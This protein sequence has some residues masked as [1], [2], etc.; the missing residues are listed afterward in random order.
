MA[1]FNS[2]C[3]SASPC[4]TP[5]LELE[6]CLR[7]F[8]DAGYSKFEAFTNWNASHLDL[9]ADPAGYRHLADNLGMTF[10]SMHLP[11]VKEDD[12]DAT[13][14]QAVE[15]TRFAAV[16]GAPVVLFKASDR[17][18]YIRAAGPYLDAIDGLGVTPVLQNHAGSPITTPADFREVITG[19]NDARMKTLL[20]VG[21]FHYV[22]CSW[23]E[24]YDLLGDSIALV[25]LKDMVGKQSV[26]FGTG[27]V[28]ITGLIHQLVSDN[29]AGDLV[30]EMQVTDE[31][32]TLRYLGEAHKHLTN[33]LAKP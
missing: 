28:D 32:N 2:S 24:G 9:T 6:P 5:K 17:P 13:L 18:T 29:F 22:G 33:L 3:L 7:A 27:E 14:Q 19:I 31:E 21:Y 8:R 16:L 1:S 20:E 10:S 30:V 26:P 15:G 23:Q 4:S 12:F 11:P 25:H